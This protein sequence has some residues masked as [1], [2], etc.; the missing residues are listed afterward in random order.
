MSRRTAWACRRAT[1]EKLPIPV[2]TNLLTLLRR[3]AAQAPD[4]PC[5]TCGD[6]T[7]GFATFDARASRV[8]NA[9]AAQ[10]VQA[11]DRVAIIA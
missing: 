10:G 11:G 1:D 4:A 9:L 5:L 3:H 6:E 2:E 8:A 7:Q